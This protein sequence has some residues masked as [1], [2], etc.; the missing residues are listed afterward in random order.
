MYK[1]LDEC[2][3][4]DFLCRR[5]GWLWEDHTPFDGRK[6]HEWCQCPW[7][8]QEPNA[9]ELCAK[10]NQTAWYGEKCTNHMAC[11]CEKPIVT[12]DLAEGDCPM[13]WKNHGEQCYLMTTKAFSHDGC[14]QTC[15]E[16]NA[17]ISSVG[18]KQEHQALVNL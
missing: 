6:Y 7:T 14:V 15:A 9:G 5:Q 1:P 3:D 10:I 13:G 17:V 11:L 2:D 16:G 8:K 12:P 18:N 4:E